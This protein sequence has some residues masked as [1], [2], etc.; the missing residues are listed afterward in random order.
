MAVCKGWWQ[1]EYVC[2]FVSSCVWRVCSTVSGWGGGSEWLG[3]SGRT[4]IR[5]KRGM[6]TAVSFN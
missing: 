5:N 3:V 4:L 6:P 1:Y 2:V